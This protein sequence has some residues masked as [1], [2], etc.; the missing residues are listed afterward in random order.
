MRIESFPVLLSQFPDLDGLWD[1]DDL[2]RTEFEITQRLPKEGEGWNSQALELLS[3]KARV[4]GLLGKLPETNA[5]LTKLKTLLAEQNEPQK[6]QRAQIRFFIEQGRFLG[7]SMSKSHSIAF[8]AQAMEQATKSGEFYFAVEAA[9]M[10][11]VS[12]PPKSQYEWL[13]KAIQI[14]ETS[15]DEQAKLW[16]SILYTME[17]WHVYDLRRFE[18]ALVSFEKALARPQSPQDATRITTIKWSIGLTLR[19]LNRVQEALDLQRKLM[20]EL[21]AVGKINGYVLL[22]IAEC[23]QLLGNHDEART[24]FE[25]A[26]KELSLNGWYADNKGLELNRI[27]RLSKR[28]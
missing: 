8:F 9:L 16:L 26:Y 25:S 28:R 18:E 17:A 11:S 23:L 1:F 22:E 4:Q 7:L 27:Q 14:A 21:T 6:N 13:K 10:L 5:T 19:T 24:Y 2:Q 3:Q 12:Q 20:E 15:G